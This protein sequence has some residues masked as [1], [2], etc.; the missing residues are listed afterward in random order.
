[1]PL[2]QLYFLPILFG[3][4]PLLPQKELTGQSVKDPSLS[5]SVLTEMSPRQE[6]PVQLSELPNGNLVYSTLDGEIY[7]ILDNR[8]RLLYDAEDH[9]LPYV[10]GMEVKGDY[11]YIC[12]S[13]VQPD[14]VTMVGYVIKGHLPSGEW[15][16]LAKSDPYFLGRS[17]NDH[18]FS[19]LLVSLDEQF[20]FVHSGTR[21]NA[22]E[23]HELDGIPATN[24]LRDQ[25]IRG[26]LFKIPTS[27]D[28]TIHLSND[29]TILKNSPYLYVEGLRH[30]FAMAWGTDGK[31]YGGS[32][33]DRRDVAEAFYEIKE[34]QHYGFPWWIGG[35]PNPIQFSDYDPDKDLLLPGNANNQGYYDNDPNFPMMPDNIDFVQPY[36]N[37]GPDADRYRDAQTGN[38][39]DA[40]AQ[41]RSTTTFSP[42]RSPTGLVFDR[43]R[44]LSPPFEGDAFMVSYTNNSR[45]LNSDGHDLLHLELIGDD[46]LSARQL[47]SGF[48]HPID[49]ILKEGKLFILELG[50]SNGTGR[51]IYEVTFD[52]TTSNQSSLKDQPLLRVFPNPSSDHLNLTWPESWRVKSIQIYNQKGENQL[53]FTDPKSSIDIRKLPAQT[54]YL[55]VKFENGRI[56]VQPFVKTQN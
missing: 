34:G 20:V 42:H 52:A 47:I 33:S 14:Q 45:L 6:I 8:P 48:I 39:M 25:P 4:S 24:N 49:V 30:L 22:G 21:T 46:T 56:L 55:E 29:S 23:V 32:N 13:V 17:F 26:K 38:I 35:E 54:Y 10:S 11:I 9:D 7:E 41:G 28:T 18:R 36:K 37:I 16:I 50:N 40:S 5:I 3:L 51:K 31:F 12:G 27:T 53:F 43:Q 2:K 15:T 44:L 19:A 1:M